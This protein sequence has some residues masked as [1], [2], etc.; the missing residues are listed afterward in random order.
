M[1]PLEHYKQKS[2]MDSHNKHF[3][4]ILILRIIVGKLILKKFP[5]SMRNNST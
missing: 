5:F 4:K 1:P 3:A 2:N